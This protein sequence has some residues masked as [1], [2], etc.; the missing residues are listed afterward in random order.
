MNAI[1]KPMGFAAASPETE[2]E[3]RPVL[4][5]RLERMIVRVQESSLCY[6]LVSLGNEAGKGENFRWMYNACKKLDPSWPVHYE[7]R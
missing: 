5:E 4:E 3:F 2:R 1:L 7:G 6:Y